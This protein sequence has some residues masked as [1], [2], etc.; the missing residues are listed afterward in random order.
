MVGSALGTP[1]LTGN[2]PTFNMVIDPT[3]MLPA[4][5]N[6]LDFPGKISLFSIGSG[7]APTPT[8]PATA[9][10]SEEAATFVTFLNAP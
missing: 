4:T 2:P 1:R 3:G 7:G 10:T 8:T 6:N 5:A 9:G